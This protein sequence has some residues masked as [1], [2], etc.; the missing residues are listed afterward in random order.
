M[1]NFLFEKNKF[2]N[3]SANGKNSLLRYFLAIFSIIIFFFIAQYPA[4][5]LM[6]HAEFDSSKNTGLNF[7]SASNPINTEAYLFLI[8]LGLSFLLVC[9]G[10]FFAVEFVHNRNIKTLIT[11]ERNINFQKIITGFLTWFAISL[12]VITFQFV[13]NP[14]NFELTFQPNKFL[15]LLFFALIFLFIQTATE[16]IIFRAYLSQSLYYFLRQPL[17]VCIISS[18]AFAFVHLGNPEISNT[19]EL[20]LKIIIFSSYFLIGLFL[21]LISLK[22]NSIELAIGIHAAN[23]IFACTVCNYAN[24]ALPTPSILTVKSINPSLDLLLLISSIIIFSA[25][26]FLI[27][28]ISLKIKL[29][30]WQKIQA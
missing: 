16:E 11:C 8:F 30:F 2:L 27:N 6:L 13:T 19:E 15:F 4:L 21:S 20:K 24:S 1:K 12:L 5:V 25:Y 9:I 18:I 29:N 14:D 7:N 26:I 22:Q 10:I 17:L 3:L 23:N 28:K